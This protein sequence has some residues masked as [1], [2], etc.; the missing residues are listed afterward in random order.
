MSAQEDIFDV[1]DIETHEQLIPLGKRPRRNSDPFPAPSILDSA[2]VNPNLM[3]NPGIIEYHVDTCIS[4]K[5][6]LCWLK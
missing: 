5:M 2:N 6:N 4:K 3:V 1:L